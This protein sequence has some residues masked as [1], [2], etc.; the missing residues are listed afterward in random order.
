LRKTGLQNRQGVV[1]NCIGYGVRDSRARSESV[2]VAL[3][4]KSEDYVTLF[5]MYILAI[6]GRM[7]EMF[8]VYLSTID[9]PPDARFL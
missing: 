2:E 9:L 4:A 5:G 1:L 8:E 6:S 7:K 3:Q